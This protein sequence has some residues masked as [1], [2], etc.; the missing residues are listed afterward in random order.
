MTDKIKFYY[1]PMSRARMVHWML[2]EVGAEYEIQLIDFEKREHKSPEYLAVN[3]MGKIPAIVH[4]G[5]VITETPAICAYLADAFPHAGLAPA[6]NSPERGTYYRWLFFGASCLEPTILDKLFSRPA[7]ER[8]GALGYGTYEVTLGALEKALTPGPYI[9]GSRF[10]AADLFL[11]SEIGWG[12]AV[13]ALEPI[14]FLKKY[15]TICTDR[16]AFKRFV[17]QNKQ[18]SEKMKPARF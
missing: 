3:P 7:P 18:I 15:N 17:E 14:D 6:I 10:S 9:L 8:P 4:K 16:P 2:E 11:A 1:N 5:R 13:N 12:I